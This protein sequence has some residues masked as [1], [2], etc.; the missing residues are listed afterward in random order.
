M[1]QWTMAD[2]ERLNAKR[3]ATMPAHVP[4]KSKY[5]NVKT[6]VGTEKFDSKR[7]AQ[8]WA[9]LKLREKAGDISNLR[10]QQPL[11]LCCPTTPNQSV[12]VS[13]YIADFV[14][15]DRDFKTHVVD[16]K[17]KRTQMYTLKKKWLELQSGVII[18]EV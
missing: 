8:Y 18:E 15:Q 4:T 12:V 14:Y 17:G 7:E 2:I 10:R 11:D 16:A 1:S 9:E 3:G 13:Q 5:R 6:M